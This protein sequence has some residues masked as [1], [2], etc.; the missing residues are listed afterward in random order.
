MRGRTGETCT[1]KKAAEDE[2]QQTP[3]G[4]QWVIERT[5]SIGAKLCVHC[6]AHDG[7]IT[8]WVGRLRVS[9]KVGRYGRLGRWTDMAGWEG[10]PIWPG[11]KPDTV[12]RAFWLERDGAAI[13]YSQWYLPNGS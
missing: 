1:E 11:G 10:G 3:A 6:G 9:G 8:M 13:R 5:L 2:T 4:T 12:R 7:I